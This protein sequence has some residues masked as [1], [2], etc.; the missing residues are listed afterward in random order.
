MLMFAFDCVDVVDVAAP[1]FHCRVVGW[2]VGRDVFA[3]SPPWNGS[4]VQAVDGH[5]D[6][7]LDLCLMLFCRIRIFPVNQLK[8]RKGC[9]FLY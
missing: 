2:Q 3:S 6:S 8:L 9:C 7:S 4:S 5:V 1:E